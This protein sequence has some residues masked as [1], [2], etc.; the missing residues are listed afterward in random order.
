MMIAE[1]YLLTPLAQEC[2]D[3]QGWVD[4]WDN[5]TICFSSASLPIQDG[6]DPNGGCGQ[7]FGSAHTGYM[8]SVFADG[9][10]HTISY[11]VSK[12]TWKNLC[13]RDDGQALGTDW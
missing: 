2:D 9:S 3:D 12:T 10:V 5:D 11:H 4:G 6:T 1:K 13:K 7:I 8:Q